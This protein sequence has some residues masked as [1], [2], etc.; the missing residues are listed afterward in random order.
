MDL[1][2]INTQI[3]AS[4]DIKIDL[5]WCGLLLDNW[6]VGMFLFQYS[7]SDILL[8]ISTNSQVDC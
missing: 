8:I 7:S 2:F 1:F 3:F 5:L 4:Q 6:D